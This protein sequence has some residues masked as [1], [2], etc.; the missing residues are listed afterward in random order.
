MIEVNNGRIE[1]TPTC[2]ICQEGMSDTLTLKQLL[3]WSKI[4]QPLFCQC[5]LAGFSKIE[6]VTCGQCGREMLEEDREHWVDGICRD[7]Q[8][9]RHF[10]KWT[11]RHQSIY[12]YNAVFKQWLVVLKGQGDIRGRYLFKS[13]L[14][15]I[16]RRNRQTIW[17]PMPSSSGKVSNRGFNQ[18]VLLLEGANI[19]F[20]DLLE[21]KASSTKQVYKSRLDRLK[22]MDKIQV[23]QD[24]G[25]EHLDRGQN[26]L[27]F[28]D[29]YTTGTTMYSAY[30][31]LSDMGFTHIQ[32]L[33]L[34]R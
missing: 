12:H 11:F 27:L 1:R 30:K 8:R 4:D 22:D 5:C 29:V 18:T 16:Y 23:K 13:D 33:S 3:S 9:W 10:H 19:S 28:D 7:C 24:S 14:Q 15:S 31:A 32:G 34:A 26:I 25:I 21:M 20:M 2:L 17:V 6:G